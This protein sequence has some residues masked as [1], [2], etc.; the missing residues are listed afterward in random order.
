MH[1]PSLFNSFNSL[2]ELE[3]KLS[4]STLSVAPTSL[5]NSFQPADH[6][7]HHA[8]NQS[9]PLPNPEPP[10]PPDPGNNPPVVYPALPSSG[11]PGPA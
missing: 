2:D 11:P 9:D 7:D 1:R 5:V 6:R 3:L 10:P 8:F 4:L